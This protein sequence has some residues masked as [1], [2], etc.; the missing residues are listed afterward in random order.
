MQN[1]ASAKANLGVKEVAD[2]LDVSDST[3]YEMINDGE[4]SCLIIR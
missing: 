2:F 1:P 3:V 4:L